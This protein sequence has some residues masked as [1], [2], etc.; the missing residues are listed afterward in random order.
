MDATDRIRPRAFMRTLQWD[1]L[2]PGDMIM[3]ACTCY[4]HIDFPRDSSLMF[5][6]SICCQKCPFKNTIMQLSSHRQKN[7]TE[8]GAARSS[9]HKYLS[10]VAE[11][12]NLGRRRSV[13]RGPARRSQTGA[14]KAILPPPLRRLWPPC[15]T[16][17]TPFSFSPSCHPSCASFRYPLWHHAARQACSVQGAFAM[18]V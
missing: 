5:T 7:R 1:Q 6:T 12:A 9:K 3:A 14:L 17:T 18:P 2:D 13:A 16:A 15:S 4:M 8:G 10:N 11:S